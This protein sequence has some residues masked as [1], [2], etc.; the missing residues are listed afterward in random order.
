MVNEYQRFGGIIPYI[1]QGTF[2][3]TRLT[4]YTM[5]MEAAWYS[6]ILVSVYKVHE[7]AC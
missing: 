4:F 1:T 3:H 6:E 7:I 5:N 2:F